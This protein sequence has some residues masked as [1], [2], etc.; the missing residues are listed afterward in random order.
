MNKNQV[1]YVCYYKTVPFT[2]DNGKKVY[3]IGYAGY[4]D[5][6]PKINIR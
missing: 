6:F 4:E 2:A 5:H 3:S 1:I